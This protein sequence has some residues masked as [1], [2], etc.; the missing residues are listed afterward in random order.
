MA[1]KHRFLDQIEGDLFV[2]EDNSGGTGDD[3]NEF[4]SMLANEN[5]K[6]FASLSQGA[7]VE[8]RVL[9]I[10]GST[11]IFDVG[12]RSEGVLP[13]E[14]L[15]PEDKGKFKVGE[16][17]TLY[18]SS[19][20]SGIE[21]ATSLSARQAGLDGL[22]DAMNS[23]L[24]VEGKVVGENKGGYNVELPGV[25]GFCPFSQ[26]D[27]VPGKPPAAFIGQTFKF[28]VTKIAGRDVVLSRT[29]LLRE[30][31]AAE[32][33]KI[34]EG[35]KE[36]DTLTVSVVKIENFGAFVDLGGG[37]N[38]LVPISELSWSRPA[39]AHSV[40]TVGEKVIVKILKVER[41]G[42][43]PRISAS[44]KQVEG[45]PWDLLVEKLET[46]SIVE[47]RI[48]KLM[49][50]GAFAEILPGVE[51]L[52]HISELSAKRRI[53]TPGEV[54]QPEQRVQAKITGI[55]RIN[56]RI[57]L[58][59]KVLETDVVEQ[60]GKKKIEQSKNADEEHRGVE[61]RTKGATAAMG[62][63][64]LRALEKHKR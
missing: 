47:V 26:I 61:I 44:M 56:R 12:Q 37:L 60:E 3:Q 53:S 58:S 62:D 46:G 2:D 63:A 50:F 54:V 29:S 43:R 40:V 21:L 52:I 10:T 38:A 64:F 30:E 17:Y 34:L 15:S 8:G 41:T 59:M 42:D 5:G 49:Q 55:D 24:P 36:G 45:D 1:K 32:R 13:T 9:A 16:S 7:R 57:G 22:R 39:S 27:I 11:V 33:E 14:G 48:T 19:V 31:Q 28:Q 4:A 20:K 23:G 25:K 6:A 35:V 18:V 51:G